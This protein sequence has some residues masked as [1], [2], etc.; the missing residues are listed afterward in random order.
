VSFRPH[1]TVT[2][3]VAAHAL[4]GESRTERNLIVP[5]SVNFIPALERRRFGYS[6]SGVSVG[7]TWRPISDLTLGASARTGGTVTASVDDT[8]L[9][10]ADYPT[11]FGGSVQFTGIRGI[12][13]AGRVGWTGW[14]NLE[15]LSLTDVPVTDSW[16]YGAGLE[17]R[18]P[19]LLGIVPALRLGF[20]HS[21]LPYGL[22][23]G[24]EVTENAFSG[25][26][27][28]QIAGGRGTLDLTI[29]RLVRD[30]PGDV[31]ERAWGIG[32]G[33]LLRL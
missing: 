10:T 18:G 25:G 24:S 22:P 4:T 28:F 21:T 1:S 31:S 29:E 7:A 27:G 15:S 14:S 32:F 2:V 19:S 26:L 16:E 30:A 8:T 23:D 33:M 3:R 6:G 9:S 11:R 20:R 17:G 12:V 13:L 5:D